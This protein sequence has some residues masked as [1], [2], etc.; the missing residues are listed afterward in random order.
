L[1]FSA[2]HDLGFF[3]DSVSLSLIVGLA[4]TISPVASLTPYLIGFPI[5]PDWKLLDRS[6]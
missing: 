4:R 6:M 5:S 3:A 2:I 1:L